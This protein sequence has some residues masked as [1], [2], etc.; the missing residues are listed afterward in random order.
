M[1]YAPCF[2]AVSMLEGAAPIIPTEHLT[3]NTDYTHRGTH[4]ECPHWHVTPPPAMLCI[5]TVLG[6]ACRGQ[7][8]SPHLRTSATKTAIVR[9][10]L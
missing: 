5:Q 2:Y 6:I 9:L 8:I 10:L 4:N 1:Y 3:T 7:Q